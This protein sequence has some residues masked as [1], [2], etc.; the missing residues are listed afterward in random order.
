MS[1]VLKDSMS[2]ELMAVA[3]R[4]GDKELI[5]RIADERSVTSVEELVPWLE[6]HEHPALAMDPI[7]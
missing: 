7:F 2:A 4:E 6:A 5:D 3:E 1:S